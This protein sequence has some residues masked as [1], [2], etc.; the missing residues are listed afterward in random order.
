MCQSEAP[1]LSS[2]LAHHPFSSQQIPEAPIWLLSK[3]RLADARQS[4]RRLRGGVSNEA[5][6]DEFESLQQSYKQ[7]QHCPTCGQPADQ[8]KH[9]Q[10]SL[11][12]QFRVVLQMSTLKPLIL[13]VCL[14]FLMQF[15]AVFSMRAYMVPVLQAHATIVD[16]KQF[17]SFLGVIG[18][19][20][21]VVIVV[22]IRQM[23]KRAIYLSSQIGNIVA[24]LLLGECERV[25]NVHSVQFAAEPF[26]SLSLQ[27]RCVWPQ[28]FPARL[29]VAERGQSAGRT[30]AGA[31]QTHSGRMELSGGGHVRGHAVFCEQWCVVG[32]VLHALRS[33]SVQVNC[34]LPFS[35]SQK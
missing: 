24:C 28:V 18:I 30:N 26:T 11:W 23:G 13:V 25:R 20:A 7:S 22:M 19:A 12:S 15:S 9:V 34:R 5:I 16:A 2:H 29:D 33:V 32:A 17:N 4:L 8:C 14:F 3:N 21:N 31:Q 10:P 27:C 1:S 35:T 6:A